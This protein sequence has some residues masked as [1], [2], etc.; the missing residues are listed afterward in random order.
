MT[1][2]QLINALT[3]DYI[4][5]DDPVVIYG[6]SPDYVTAAVANVRSHHGRVD[7]ETELFDV[8]SLP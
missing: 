7:L 6:P 3:E 5:L 8:G 4:D 1:V 2:R